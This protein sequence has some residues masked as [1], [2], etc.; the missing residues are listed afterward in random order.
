MVKITKSER[1]KTHLTTLESISHL[2]DL[3]S[4]TESQGLL[5]SLRTEG[6]TYVK[7]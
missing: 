5:I 6:A 2:G 7:P 1:V 4:G 3:G